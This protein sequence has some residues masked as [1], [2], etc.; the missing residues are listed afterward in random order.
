VRRDFKLPSSDEDYLEGVG[1]P[2]ET[3]KEG[4]Q[5]W[6]LVHNWK[7]IAGYS[8]DTV[9][10]ALAI[11][12]NYAD[13]QIDSFNV[14]PILKRNDG[15][16]IKNIGEPNIDSKKFQFWSRHRSPMNPWRPGVD[17]IASHLSLVQEWLRRSLSD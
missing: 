5:Q 17:D 4:T 3:V 15:G 12:V 11:D 2:W 10:I 8:S 9:T 14:Y 1:L 13:T 16:P 6:L 7:V